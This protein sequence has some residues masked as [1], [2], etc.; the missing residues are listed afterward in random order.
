MKCASCGKQKPIML[1][2]EPGDWQLCVQC[3]LQGF[4]IGR[5]ASRKA[6]SKEP[7]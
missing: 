5:K 1:T 3:W 4:G 2:M 6:E 7:S